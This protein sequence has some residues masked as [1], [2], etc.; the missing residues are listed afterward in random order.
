MMV[1]HLNSSPEFH[2]WPPQIVTSKDFQKRSRVTSIAPS[3]ESDSKHHVPRMKHLRVCIHV[4]E[5]PQNVSLTKFSSD[6]HNQSSFLE[7]AVNPTSCLQF[8]RAYLY[9]PY[10][11]IYTL[12]PPRMTVVS[13]VPILSKHRT[14]H[15]TST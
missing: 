12:I 14:F 1:I 7:E 9:R 13:R 6:L 5:S 8:T 15:K 10:L 4:T 3:S 11:Q 2:I